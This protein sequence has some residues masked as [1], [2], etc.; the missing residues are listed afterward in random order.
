VSRL[1]PFGRALLV[2]VIGVAAVW[3]GYCLIP[4]AQAETYE[5]SYADCAVTWDEAALWVDCEYDRTDLAAPEASS[6]WTR[7]S[8]EAYAGSDP[9]PWKWFCDLEGRQREQP[10][11]MVYLPADVI[12]QADRSRRIE[13]GLRWSALGLEPDVGQETRIGLKVN[14]QTDQGERLAPDKIP[15]GLDNDPATFTPFTLTESNRRK[16]GS[17]SPPQHP[18]L[19][20]TTLALTWDS[21]DDADWWW[22]YITRDGEALPRVRAQRN[23]YPLET[24]IEP[25]AA[26]YRFEVSAEA[27]GLSESDRSDPYHTWILLA[28]R[29][30][31]CPEVPDCPPTVEC[32]DPEPCPDCPPEVVCPPV[33][34]C[35][36]CP[37]S[38]VPKIQEVI[39]S[40]GAPE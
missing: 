22:V 24:V 33:V 32:P 21:Q 38:L 37:A 25:G 13:T 2:Y 26:Q 14:A 18:A 6:I 28:E 16:A 1:T 19:D 12:C 4:W 30:A 3:L 36:E 27:D 7:T 15:E 34:E 10:A 17:A 23:E 29:E 8:V 31:E 40:C 39:V 35:P 11:S 5:T 9:K 20:E